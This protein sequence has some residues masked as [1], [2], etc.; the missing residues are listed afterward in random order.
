M[1]EKDILKNLTARLIEQYY[2]CL[3][4]SITNLAMGTILGKLHSLLAVGTF[5]FK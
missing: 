1:F 5:L 2:Q 3:T 4:L